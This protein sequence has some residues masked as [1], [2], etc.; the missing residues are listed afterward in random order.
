MW[1]PKEKSYSK[2]K[3]SWA[4]NDFYLKS[5]N[6]AWK[7]C[8]KGSYGSMHMEQEHLGWLR[9]KRRTETYVSV[10][11]R[12]KD[13]LLSFIH[14][15]FAHLET[16]LRKFGRIPHWFIGNMDKLKIELYSMETFCSVKHSNAT[17]KIQYEL[18]HLKSGCK[19]I[20][21]TMRWTK[22][23]QNVEKNDKAIEQHR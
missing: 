5:L 14:Y 3:S 16:I 8:T 1:D 6:R 21:T 10:P 18:P 7:T 19:N 20:V 12:V 4:E 15:Q 11:K 22:K 9:M 2:M 17:V 23:A 13:Y